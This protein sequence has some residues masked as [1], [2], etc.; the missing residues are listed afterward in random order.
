MSS[1]SLIA[2]FPIP[3]GPARE[4]AV[5]LSLDGIH[6]DVIEALL[7]VA[8]VCGV[9]LLCTAVWL[10]AAGAHLQSGGSHAA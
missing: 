1:S 9:S 8:T 6:G 10:L 2:C 4:G 5:A 3:S 7:L